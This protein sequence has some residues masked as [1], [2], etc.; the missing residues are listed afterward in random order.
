MTTKTRLF[1]IRITDDKHARFKKLAEKS[2]MSMGAILNN[3]IDA[4]LKDE[5]DIVGLEQEGKI[6]TW[7]DPLSDIRG[8]Y[9]P[10]VDF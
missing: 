4:I 10:G 2:D 1:N 5:V 7:E 9:T 3:Y 6:A 8:Q